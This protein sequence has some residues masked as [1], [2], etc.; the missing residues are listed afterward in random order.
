MAQQT[1]PQSLLVLLVQEGL[2]E[3][4]GEE[5]GEEPVLQQALVP[6]VRGFD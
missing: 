3:L 6:A 1:Q 2:P 4:L 5:E